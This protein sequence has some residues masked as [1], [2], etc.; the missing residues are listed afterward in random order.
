MADSEAVVVVEG[1]V[2]VLGPLD[3][4]GSTSESPAG[5]QAVLQTTESPAGGPP[6][7]ESSP[8]LSSSGSSPKDTRLT[9]IKIA[10][11]QSK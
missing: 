7:H 8:L 5:R 2:V 9:S 4:Y 3:H 1:V 10:F 6:D 11:T